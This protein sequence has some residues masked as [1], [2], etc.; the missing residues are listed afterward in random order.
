MKIYYDPKNDLLHIILREVK[1]VRNE[2]YNDDIV[3][4][5]DKD[6]RVVGLEILD[7]SDYLE[8]DNLLSVTVV[9]GKAT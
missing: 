7:A 5:V 4:D 1:Q 8:L 2:R 6:G 9:Q 3:F